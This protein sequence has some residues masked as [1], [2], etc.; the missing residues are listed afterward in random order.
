[1]PTKQLM[2]GARKAMRATTTGAQLVGAL[3]GGIAL[4]ANAA[5]VTRAATA[6]SGFV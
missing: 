4:A 2:S 5:D 1:M 3:A 6:G